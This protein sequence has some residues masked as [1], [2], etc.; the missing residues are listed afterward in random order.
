[1]HRS[2]G[3]CLTS[4]LHAWLASFA[5]AWRRFVHYELDVEPD[6][7]GQEAAGQQLGA[8]GLVVPQYL[9]VRALDYYLCYDMPKV[10]TVVTLSALRLWLRLQDVGASKR[11]LGMHAVCCYDMLQAVV[12]SCG[13]KVCDCSWRTA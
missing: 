6:Q 8:G 2:H 11:G 4:Q 5:W 3:L 13:F 9:M 1:M 10:V 12:L 7:P